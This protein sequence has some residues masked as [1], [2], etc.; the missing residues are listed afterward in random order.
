MN[1]YNTNVDNITCSC[2]D[3]K[4]T[5]STYPQNDPRRL[6]KHLINKMHINSLPTSLKYFIE[7]IE[8]YKTKEWGFR[9]D[10]EKVLT[11][12][13][14]N[15]TVLMTFDWMNIYDS[16]G[17]KYGYLNDIYT[18]EHW[19]AKKNK[20]IG[21]EEV[22]EFFTKQFKPLPLS[23]QGKEKSDLIKYIKEVI[24]NKQNIQ[25][26]IEE[27]QWTPSPDG[28]YYCL[29]ESTSDYP[30]EEEVRHI[31]VNNNEIII[32]MYYG[33]IF[34]YN[35]DYEYAKSFIE[36]TRQKEQ[37]RL[38][39]EKQ[40]YEEELSAKR[41]RAKSKGYLWQIKDTIYGE[42]I[43]ISKRDEKSLYTDYIEVTNKISVEYSNTKKL[44]EVSK[45]S[46]TSL[47]FH[48]TLN[49]L[50]MIKKVKTLNLNEWIILNDGLKYGINIEKDSK[51]FTEIIPDWYMITTINVNTLE[52]VEQRDRQNVRMTKVLWKNNQFKELLELVIKHI[53]NQNSEK[54]LVEK[55]S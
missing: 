25:F 17:N 43:K 4:Q 15:L 51:Y 14:N 18:G 8:F 19:W 42:L 3:W 45:S 35:R 1:I 11:F 52:L 16:D 26:S 55:T 40:K 36:N 54:D 2:E 28:I 32:E 50:K 20:P 48:K 39:N 46:I 7:D 53:K 30:L 5:R 31:I 24:P 33:E 21:Y 34:Q 27:D 49:K 13:I 44:L 38:D 9:Q 22:E 47:L 6:C 41:D 23:L 12:P 37:K 29:Y 10:F